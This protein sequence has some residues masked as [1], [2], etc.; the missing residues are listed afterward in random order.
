M[1]PLQRSTGFRCGSCCSRAG[2]PHLPDCR[3][4]KRFDLDPISNTGVCA[5]ELAPVPRDALE[6]RYEAPLAELPEEEEDAPLA[7]P[8]EEEEK[9]T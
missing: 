1:E 7:E 8:T 2:E 4:D 6:H 9:A 5:L 3:R